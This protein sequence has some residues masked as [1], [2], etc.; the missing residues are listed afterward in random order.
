MFAVVLSVRIDPSRTEDAMSDL[1]TIVVP[2]AKAAP[3]FIRGTWCGG[4]GQGHAMMLFDTRENA[5][6]A[7]ETAT[8]PPGMAAQLDR[9]GT[10]E[11]RAEA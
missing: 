9:V 6:K 8:P 2:G 4:D 11:V 5:E 7:A 10:F 1:A 3:G